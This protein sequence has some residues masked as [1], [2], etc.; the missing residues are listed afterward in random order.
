VS[1]EPTTATGGRARWIALA[2]LLAA[3]L[4][5]LL[6]ATTVNIAIPTI[7]RDLGTT[8]TSVQW[9]AAGY[10]LAFAVVLITGGRLGDILGRKRVFLGAMA[11]FTVAS[12][13]SGMAVNTEMLI[14][15][16]VL[17]GVAA[18]LMVPQV[19]SIMHVS[20][21]PEE[22]GKVFGIFGAVAGIGGV[23]GPMV[24]ALLVQWNLFGLAWRPIF[25][26][27]L[28]ICLVALYL[29]GR[30]ITESKAPDK[31][32]LDLVGVL[33]VAAALLLLLYP[34]T[35]GRDLDWPGWTFALMGA[36]VVV[37]GGFLLQ[38]RHRSRTVGSP[39]V[40]L[41]L[42]KIRSFSAGIV[43]QLVFGITFGLFSLCGALYMQLGLGW[44]PLRT[45]LVSLFFG[46]TMGV[47]AVVG[48]QKI[49]PKFGT[50]T[51]QGGAVLMVIGLLL[52]RTFAGGL[53]L[54]AQWWQL[55]LPLIITGAGLGL[56]MAPLT[57]TIMAEVPFQD[58]GS[59]SGVVNTVSQVGLSAGLAL[60][61]VAFF[62]VIDSLTGSVSSRA[63]GDV[64]I[65]GFTSA[66]WWVIGG[67]VI[68][69]G[70]LFLLPAKPPN[71]FAAPAQAEGA[72]TDDTQVIADTETTS[73]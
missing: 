24:G 28:P 4:L 39:L 23:S 36:G 20:F 25:L 58:A 70:L 57:Q 1:T 41:S 2:V 43:V 72:D 22:A 10:T 60:N 37:F 21:R 29:G 6:D 40:A 73:V 12:A 5:D 48:I 19:L 16:R 51:L 13:L 46:V 45:A 59:A 34:L 47:C 69:F 54:G 63:T 62:A 15:S 66:L 30:Y 14:A 7:Q 35:V 50:R 38:Q 27:N 67:A 3:T 33:L 56:I 26:V 52:Y 55:A 8:F 65:T 64:V 11:T 42:F 44:T 49:V 71:P 9:I 61:A 18:A 17:Q 31:P 68:V 53:G 32:R